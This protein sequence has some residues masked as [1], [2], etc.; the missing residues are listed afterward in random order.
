MCISAIKS[1]HYT[2]YCTLSEC[3]I[4]GYSRQTM[5][6]KVLV[7]IT[8]L[9]VGDIDGA[10]VEQTNAP[11]SVTARPQSDVALIRAACKANEAMAMENCFQV[12]QIC[13]HG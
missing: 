13:L 3:N 4:F 5:L 8:V 12:P 9:G 1:A 10:P 2:N 6:L 7:V 11:S